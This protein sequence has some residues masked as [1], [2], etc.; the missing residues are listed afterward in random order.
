[1]NFNLTIK[2]TACDVTDASIGVGRVGLNVS[3]QVSQAPVKVNEMIL[4][5]LFGQPLT[6]PNL[7]VLRIAIRVEAADYTVERAIISFNDDL[8]TWQAT[9]PHLTPTGSKTD[10]AI[11]ARLGVM[12]FAPLRMLP[13]TTPAKSDF[14]PGAS[15]IEPRGN[16]FAY[17]ALWLES[18]YVARLSDP[19]PGDPAAE[20]WKRFAHEK[21]RCIARDFGTFALLEFG[22][23]APNTDGR[24][25][26]LVAVW[27]PN[28][29]LGDTAD[30]NVFFSPNT[31]QAI[32]PAD[33]YPADSYPFAKI[34][35]YQ[36]KPKKGVL[37]PNF[38]LTDLHAPYVG[39][40]LNYVGIGYKIVYQMLAARKN[41][42]IVMPIQPASQWGPLQTRTCLWRLVLEVVRF[43]EAERLIA[44]QGKVG[45][46][47]LGRE[48]ASVN[49]NDVGPA[50]APY[51]RTQIR[52]TT[53]AFSAGLSAMLSLISTEKLKEDKLFPSS[54]F[55]AADGEC[56]AA[57]RAIWDVD[58]AF[59]QLG[60]FE[61]CMRPMLAWRKD[62]PARILRMYHSNDQVDADT[63]VAALMPEVAIKRYPGKTGFIDQGYAKDRSTLWV[64][65]SN[66]TLRTPS[67]ADSAAGLWPLLGSQGAHWMVPT[68][69]FG[70][71]W[72][73][74]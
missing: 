73:I 64:L 43:G 48:G 57:W 54:H 15:L 13:E 32:D 53:S 66:S 44:R 26:F 28:Q 8:G 1:M 46:L 59:H 4:S 16:T 3:Q 31:G 37:G 71:A 61:A 5:T 42:I 62:D 7:V 25:R 27:Y 47:D 60:G 56:K 29:P 70:H 36:M 34:Y 50:S 35:P 23:P 17:R 39:L 52:V 68:V 63:P 9:N 19:I 55:A 41:A 6:I 67:P 38:T 18:T 30:V 11:V 21:N 65:F 45:R 10:L 74:S 12:R 69:A 72:L 20:D 58:G 49:T 14:N 51:T 40:A 22:F 24:P 33:S 2:I